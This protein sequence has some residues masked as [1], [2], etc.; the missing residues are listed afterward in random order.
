MHVVGL[1]VYLKLFSA[2]QALL[3]WHTTLYK[4]HTRVWEKQR[5]HGRLSLPY[6][7]TDKVQHTKGSDRPH[8]FWEAA[9]NTCLVY[10]FSNFLSIIATPYNDR[11]VSQN[12]L[13]GVL[14]RIRSKT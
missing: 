2:F 14:I 7:H 10:L 8:V 6:F 12:I 13:G 9:L 3:V 5:Q 1:P 11:I 4:S